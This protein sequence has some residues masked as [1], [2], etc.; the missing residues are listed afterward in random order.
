LAPGMAV[1]EL[2]CG[3]GYFSRAVSERLRSGNFVLVDI[4][5]EM[6]EMAVSRVSDVAAVHPVQGDAL[7]LPFRDDAFDVVFVVAVLG[8]TGD[9]AACLREVH[10]VLRPGGRLSVSEIR[11]DDDFIPRSALREL[12]AG[13]GFEQERSFGLGWSYT[14]NFVVP[15]ASAS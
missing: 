5:A 4:Q 15:V 1:L 9:T 13:A 12:A 10:R 6:L 11:G 3:P 2:G 14:E 7:A 8:E